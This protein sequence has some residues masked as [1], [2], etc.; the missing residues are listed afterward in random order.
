MPSGGKL[1]EIGLTDARQDEN[2]YVYASLESN[3]ERKVPTIELCP[4][5]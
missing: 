2:G 3:M 5:G 1:K 4:P